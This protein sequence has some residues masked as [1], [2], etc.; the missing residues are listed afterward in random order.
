MSDMIAL[1]AAF[2]H[3][4]SIQTVYVRNTPIVEDNPRRWPMR[5]MQNAITSGSAPSE[6]AQVDNSVLLTALAQTRE[7]KL[8][9]ASFQAPD[10]A[11]WLVDR[12]KQRRERGLGIQKIVFERSRVP[13]NE[14]AVI[15]PP[16]QEV[17]P[18]VIWEPMRDEDE[19]G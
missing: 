12:L 5:M 2:G 7:L 11:N 8:E 14:R 9:Y 4:S 19:Q 3:V 17:V 15:L 13:D 16:L 10:Y 18:T 1:A 6:P